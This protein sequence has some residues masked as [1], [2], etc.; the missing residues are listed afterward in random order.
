MAAPMP[1]RSPQ[2]VTANTAAGPS[3]SA[4]L[5]CESEINGNIALLAGVHGQ[6][7]T[8]SSWI[9][10]L[11]TCS[12]RLSGGPLLLSVK[13]LSDATAAHNYFDQLQKTL[14]PTQQLH[15]LATLGFPAYGTG[16]G[17]VV[18]LKDNDVLEVDATQVPAHVGSQGESRNDLAYTAATDVLAC[19]TEK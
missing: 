14:P 3:A 9:N 8:T 6:I 11:Y 13:E 1:S 7:P 2:P 19:W 10:S 16:N 4:K 18:F 15:G 17:I 5:I 12:Y